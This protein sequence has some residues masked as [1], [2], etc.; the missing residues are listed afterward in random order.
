MGT[1][2]PVLGVFV[3]IFQSWSL[4]AIRYLDSDA[5][6]FEFQGPS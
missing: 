3:V 5:L 2:W 6:G 4:S 1:S